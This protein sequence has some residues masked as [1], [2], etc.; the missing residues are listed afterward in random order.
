MPRNAPLKARSMLAVNQPAGMDSVTCIWSDT[1][2]SPWAAF[3]R[4]GISA[5][6]TE[7][8]HDARPSPLKVRNF[9]SIQTLDWTPSNGVRRVV[10][11]SSTPLLTPA[12][13]R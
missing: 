12:M 6:P 2:W 13:G 5:R 7:R 4:A 11:C 1:P 3:R 10:V 9:R 8:K